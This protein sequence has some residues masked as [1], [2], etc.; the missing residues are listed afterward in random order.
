MIRFLSQ[1]GASVTRLAVGA[2]MAL[3]AAGSAAAQGGEAAILQGLNK[4][5]ARI[6]TFEAPVG[7]VVR[8]GTLEITV[9]TCLK[10]P[11]EEPPESAVFLD[12]REIRPNEMPQPRFRGWMFASSPAL[13]ALEHPV[14]DVW[15]IDCK[16]AP[17]SQ[18]PSSE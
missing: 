15:V 1:L 16:A 8:F 13:S 11:P 6:S 5:T 18:A 7:Q 14:Y 10:R 3:A 2:G 12:I 17:T 4:V 9:R